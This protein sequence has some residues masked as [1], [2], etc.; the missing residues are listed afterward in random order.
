MTKGY[1]VVNVNVRDADRYPEYARLAQETVAKYGGRYL[2][3]GAKP[4]VAEGTPDLARFVILEFPS[5]EQAR[6]WYDSDEYRPVR[7]LRQKYADSDL[8]FIEGFGDS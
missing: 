4:I 8:F 2:V 3:R 1:V 6:R 5:L 7:A